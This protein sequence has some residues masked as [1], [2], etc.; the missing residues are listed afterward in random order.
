MG[1]EDD[2]VGSCGEVEVGTFDLKK[3]ENEIQIIPNWTWAVIDY[4]R[5][6]ET[7]NTATDL[8]ESDKI[9]VSLNANDELTIKGAEGKKVAIIDATGRRILDFS[10]SKENS[11]SAKGWSQGVYFIKIGEQ[12]IKIIK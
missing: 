4:I 7:G 11:I 8:I 2:E 9:S 5:L 12:T 10:A 1:T 6:S 3:G